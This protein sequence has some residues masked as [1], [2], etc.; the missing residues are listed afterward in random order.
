MNESSKEKNEKEDENKF[1]IELVSNDLMIPVPSKKLSGS[2]IK[3][4]LNEKN[5]IFVSKSNDDLINGVSSGTNQSSLFNGNS[6]KFMLKSAGLFKSLNN[7]QNLNGPKNPFVSVPR[8]P[9]PLENIDVQHVSFM[10]P[11]NSNGIA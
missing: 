8:N 5:G 1:K 4:D 10:R 7:S 6:F 11:Q 2:N 3:T 9:K